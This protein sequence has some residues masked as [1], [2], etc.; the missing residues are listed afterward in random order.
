M[1]PKTRQLFKTIQ[2]NVQKRQQKAEPVAAVGAD[3]KKKKI[4]ASV[5]FGK[6]FLSTL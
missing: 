1:N 6:H 3:G 4:K 5:M 2:R